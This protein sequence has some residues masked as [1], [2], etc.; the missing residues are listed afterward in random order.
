MNKFC[1]LKPYQLHG[2]SLTLAAVIFIAGCA[3]T[4]P[5]TEQMA[6]SKVAI[7]SAISAGGNE[8]ASLLLKSAIEKMDTAEL[9]MK[10]KKYAHARQLAEQAQVDAQLVE[11]TAHSA[12]AQ[13]AAD[14][15]QED[16][17]VLRQELERKSK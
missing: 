14:A 3:S 5:P 15:L 17:R 13:K 6:I 1:V 4:T 12:K 16:S 8:H 7:S 2:I 10:A 11:A 9:A